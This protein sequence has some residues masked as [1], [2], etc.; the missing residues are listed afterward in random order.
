MAKKKVYMPIRETVK[1]A[2]LSKGVNVP[3]L[4]AEVGCSCQTLYNYLSHRHELRSDILEK[5]FRAL[6]LHII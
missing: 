5:V 2:M 6:G 1:Q 4:A 3:F